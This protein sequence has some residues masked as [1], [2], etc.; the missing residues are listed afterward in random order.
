MMLAN[1]DLFAFARRQASVLAVI[2]L[3]ATSLSTFAATVTNITLKYTS[4]TWQMEEGLP[5]NGVQAIAQTPEGYLWVGTPKGLTRFDGAQFTVFDPQNTPELKNS[6]ITALCEG[7]DGSLWIGTAGG[8]AQLREGKFSVIP[9]S[10]GP[11]ENNIR[12]IFE[13]KDNS[14]WVGTLGGLFH[15][16]NGVWT[17]YTEKDG[18]LNSVVRSICE[19]PD[20][21]WICTASGLNIWKNGV[22]TNL[23]ELG[24]VSF[25]TVLRNR[26]G[27]IW[28]AGPSGLMCLREG[29][30]VSYTAR[31]GLA[32]NTV[33]TMHED[34]RG[35]L[36]VGTSSGLSRLVDG[37]FRVEKD[38][39]GGF[40]D[41]IDAIF[42][43][44]EGDIW[45]GG[46]DGLQELR[47]KRFTSY[48]RQQG[49][50]HNNVMSVME[51]RKGNMWL[52]TYGGGLVR[53]QDEKA[54]NYGWENSQTNGLTT[55]L[56]LALCE[57][58][59][60]SILIGTEYD[61]GTFSLSDGRFS[62]IWSREQSLIN[63]VVRV[64]YRDRE[65]NL[66]FGASSGL[67]LG[68]TKERWLEKSVVRCLLEDQAGTLWVGCNEGLFYRQNGKFVNWTARENRLQDKVIALYEDQQKNLWIGTGNS[69][70]NRYQDGK[71][72]AYTTKDGLF[73]DEIFE[74]IEDDHGWLWM[75]CSKGIFRVSKK[76]LDDFDQK[77]ARTLTS[78]AYGKADGMESVQCSG[79]AKPGVWKSRDG[80]LWF[81]TTKGLVVTDPQVSL[82]S[83]EKPPTVLIEEVIS[84]RHS[85]AF[86]PGKAPFFGFYF[87][88]VRIPPGRGDLELHFTA[89]SFPAP[90]KNRFK[91]KLEGVDRD[92]VEVMRRVA[93]YNNLRPG[94]YLFRVIACNNDGVWNKAGAN[95][96]LVMLPQ[97]WQA[98]WFRGSMALLMLA[99]A[100]GTVRYVTKRNMRQQLQRLE[101]QYAVEQERIRIARDMHDEIGAKLTKISFLGAVA[102][103]KLT[104]PEEAGAQIDKMSQTARD[105][106]RAL[107]EIVWAVNPAN[108]S[109]ED[110]ATYL[111]RNATEFFDNSPISC[112]FNIPAELPPYRLGTHVRHNVLLA[113]KEALNNVLKHSGAS[114]V[115]VQISVNASRFEVVISDNGCGFTRAELLPAS[116]V[117]IAVQSARRGNGL[118]N[119][120]HRLTS[121][122]GRCRVENRAGEGT[123]IVF[124]V[125]LK[126]RQND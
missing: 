32:G 113:A 78:I 52:G 5:Q 90:E 85:L 30:L 46:R 13:S 54:S 8:L 1:H 104:Q 19:L 34:R 92:W 43:D 42:E 88:K 100:G 120:E 2:C 3:F 58:R 10:N 112:Q 23:S 124:T 17:H 98:W 20:Q 89:L 87:P 38:G 86:Q 126:G 27:N 16:Q 24:N 79:V 96:A 28:L 49:L 75:S 53:L 47:V 51:D 56:I 61:G 33:T 76:N 91:Y 121:I 69:G 105:V 62:K 71:L 94:N 9:M 111:C 18:L 122:G 4:R 11:R 37:K 21:L 48:T 12:T 14:L 65:E 103:R 84:D 114:S 7:R 66:W 97:F 115:H 93:Y 41:Q 116:S 95:L 55:D 63:P 39:T 60:G 101:K 44:Q 119:M 118:A 102:K 81:A 83:N 57:D 109:L 107:D 106:I 117:G 25:R 6:S 108:D 35:D 68:A 22:I 73:S 26:K 72:T 45:L 125:V 15:W 50:P 77:R 110:L 67:V 36:W 31:D 80:R 64:I 82:I 29:R 123:R 70:L 59:D 99:A 40:Y 74:I